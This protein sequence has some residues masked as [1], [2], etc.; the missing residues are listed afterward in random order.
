MRGLRI[1]ATITYLLGAWAVPIH[2]QPLLDLE[3][4]STFIPE[5]RE[6][7]ISREAAALEAQAHYGG[8]VLSVE[9]ERPDSGPPFYRV[10]LLSNGNVRV[11][12]VDAQR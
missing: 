10:K 2:A 6:D 3:P 4:G 8:R 9:L 1:A 7:V 5:A 11:V 12:N